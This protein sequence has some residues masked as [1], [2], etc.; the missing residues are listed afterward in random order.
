MRV[1]AKVMV[2]WGFLGA[3][4]GAQAM[5]LSV[6]QTKPILL[7][8]GTQKPRECMKIAEDAGK[9]CAKWF[10]FTVGGVMQFVLLVGS[11]GDQENGQAGALAI[12]V[13]GKPSVTLTH[14]DAILVLK[15]VDKFM[16]PITIARMHE[17]LAPSSEVVK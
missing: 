7:P 3:A 10:E 4:S 17:T 11:Q 13:Y 16:D 2:V 12:R 6:D 8:D 1:T 5:D 9:G 15:R 14:E